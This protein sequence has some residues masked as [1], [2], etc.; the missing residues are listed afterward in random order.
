MRLSWPYL[1]SPRFLY[2][3]EE[4]IEDSA[5]EKYPL[6]DEFALAS[7]L[8]YFLWSTMP[9]E[10]LL[11]FAER[12]ELRANFAGQVNRMLK[13]QRSES[14]AENFAGQ[15]L[16]SRDIEHLDL[17][18]VG[19]LGLQPELDDVQ[20]QL[21]QQRRERE[22][23]ERQAQANPDGKSAVEEDKTDPRWQE[24]EKIR[25]RTRELRKIGDSFNDQLRTAIRDETQDY[26]NYVLRE[27]RDVLEFIDS[28]YT[29]LNATLAK[30]YGIDGVKGEE[31]RRVQLPADSPRGGVLTQATF[32]AV[33]SNPN[34]TSPV[35]RGLFVLE[36]ILGA[37][38][39]RHLRPMFL[40]SRPQPTRSRAI[41]QPFASC[42][43]SIAATPCVP[44]VMREW[45]HWASRSKIST[46]SEC[47]EKRKMS[48]RSTPPEPC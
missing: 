8:S 11:Q 30:H 41:G 14:L 1:S 12:G 6:V 17:D 46:P 40:C 38:R 36:N 45:I 39:R 34:R 23:E 33:T 32:L 48:R 21:T 26:F 44:P 42:W 25:V 37:P 29:F 5:D 43:S 13:D 2:R 31:M 3:I 47:G 7:R 19:A 24:R 16:R 27:D 22:A 20:R 10:E 4:P 35:K 18:P 9:D 15:W 28:D